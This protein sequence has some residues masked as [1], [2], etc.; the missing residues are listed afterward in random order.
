[1]SSTETEEWEVSEDLDSH[2]ESEI[3]MNNNKPKKVLVNEQVDLEMGLEHPKETVI[4]AELWIGSSE[5]HP[6]PKVKEQ[7]H[8]H[9]DIKSIPNH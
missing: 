9:W 7:D 6:T 3:L 4:K 2:N 1:M 8:N 5:S